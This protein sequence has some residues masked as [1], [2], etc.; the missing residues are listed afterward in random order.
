M[1][2]GKLKKIRRG[3]RAYVTRQI[4]KID[5]RKGD[6]KELKQMEIQLKE[7]RDTLKVLDEKI[8]ELIADE[9]TESETEGVDPIS[10][11]IEDSAGFQE[12]NVYCLKNQHDER[13]RIFQLIASV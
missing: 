11:E 6:E 4:G 5:E 7:K 12:K 9:E 10:K 2:I 13:T 3:H 8:L 1:E